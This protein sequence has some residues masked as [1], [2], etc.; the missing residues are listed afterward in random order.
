MGK[1]VPFLLLF[2]FISTSIAAAQQLSINE[3]MAV[4][5]SGEAE[6]IELRNGTATAVRP[7]DWSIEDA[8][9]KRC[10]FG[11]AVVEI[12]PGGHLVLTEA[13]PLGAAWQLTADS[14]LLLPQLPS[15]NNSGDDLVLRN[16]QGEVI[17]SLHYTSSWLGGKGYS[18][19][20]IDPAGAHE[21][22]NWRPSIAASGATPGLPNSVLPVQRNPLPPHSCRI[23]EIMYEPLTQG[24]EWVE[25]TYTGNDSLDMARLSLE[26]SPRGEAAV[27]ALHGHSGR[28]APGGYLVI[29][30]DSSILLRFPDMPRGR[31]DAVLIV[32]DRASLGL[33]NDG[34]AILLR[35]EDGTL[36]DSVVYVPDWHHP[37]VSDTRGRTLERLHPALPSLAAQS[38]STCTHNAGGTPGALNSCFTDSRAVAANEA[39]LRVDPLPFSP[40]G[41][42]YE[43]FCRI[44]CSAPAGIHEARLRIYDVQGR[45]LRTLVGG[46]PMAARMDIVWDGLDDEGRRVRIGPYVALLDMLDVANNTVRSVKGIIVVARNL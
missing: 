13:L 12:P 29:A 18:L 31:K 7:L 26:V 2:F 37:F 44:S 10:A 33:A 32:L 28:L 24:C 45:L 38:W 11:D 9:G 15:L 40:D 27:F 20:R 36:L 22:A 23:N 19:E 14:V 8:T 35:D 25:V 21:K 43:D 16:M 17:D 42:G 41:D 46:A 4:P 1:N 39:A 5:L 3:F 6:W 34:D 30:A